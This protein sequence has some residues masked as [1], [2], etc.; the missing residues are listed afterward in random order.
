MTGTLLSAAFAV[1]D[2][3]YACRCIER[4]RSARPRERRIHL[5]VAIVLF[6]AAAAF[7]ASIAQEAFA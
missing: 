5:F 7:A 1:V 4:A 2:I 3:D 6:A